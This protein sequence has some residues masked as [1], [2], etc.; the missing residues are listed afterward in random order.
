MSRL[1]HCV[2]V[3]VC[4]FLVCV[5]DS[6]FVACTGADTLFFTADQLLEGSSNYPGIYGGLDDSNIVIETYEN[7][8]ACAATKICRSYLIDKLPS[9]DDINLPVPDFPDYVSGHSTRPQ[10]LGSTIDASIPAFRPAHV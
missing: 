1:W 10:I 5:L 2:C 3:L 6:H 9:L 8:V 4:V 7:L